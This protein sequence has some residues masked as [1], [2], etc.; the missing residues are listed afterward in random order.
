LKHHDEYWAYSTSDQQK[1]G[2]WFPVLHSEDL[3][4]WGY[5]GGVLEPLMNPKGAACWAPEV[6]YQAGLFYMYY[7]AAS[8]PGDESHRLRLATAEHP[9]GPFWDTGSILL[10]EEG[11]SIDA[12]VFQDPKD[13]QW[14]CFSQKISSMYALARALQL[15]LSPTI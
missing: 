13:G 1:N 11:F 5:I 10:P 7:S 6:V 9:I 12:H 14:Y 2:R 15:Y 4:K 3:T 8:G